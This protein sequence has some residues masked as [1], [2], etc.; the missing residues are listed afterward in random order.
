MLRIYYLPQRTGTQWRERTASALSRCPW[1]RQRGTSQVWMCVPK[2][3]SRVPFTKSSR[4]S[5]NFWNHLKHL[6]TFL[7][8][9]YEGMFPEL[10]VSCAVWTYDCAPN[11]YKEL[12]FFLSWHLVLI[13][14]IRSTGLHMWFLNTALNKMSLRTRGTSVFSWIRRTQQHNLL[15]PSLPRFL[16]SNHYWV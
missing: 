10:T 6:F 16:S 8:G 13:C 15:L 4:A 9:H 7:H 3:W 1:T 12:S 5:G 11:V 2:V 14:A